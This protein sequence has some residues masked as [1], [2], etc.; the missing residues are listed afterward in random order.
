MEGKF[1]MEASQAQVFSRTRSVRVAFF[2]DIDID[3]HPVLDAIFEYCFSIWGGRFSLIIPCKNGK[4]LLEYMKWLEQYDPDLIYSY[5]DLSEEVQSQLHELLYPSSLQI[6][7]R[8]HPDQ[9]PFYAPALAIAPLSVTTL[10][11]LAGA[12]SALASTKGVRIIDAKGTLKNDRFL[13][14]SFGCAPI[15]L[16]NAMSNVLADSGSTIIAIA[17]NELQPRQHHVWGNEITVSS[18]NALLAAMSDNRSILGVAQ[19]SSMF[20]PRLNIHSHRWSGSFNI[21]IGDEI[22]DRI[23]YWNTR[24]LIPSW[25]DGRDVDLYIPREKFNDPEFIHLL[26][27]YLNK[28]NHH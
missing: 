3:L 1:S 17:E 11:P 26:R 28:R 10:L 14:D 5:I 24:S 20:T 13:L 15:E 23:L 9:P 2:V 25:R 6:H 18:I 22:A 19:L 21:V 7:F 8:G 12:P 27:V 16:R 4:P